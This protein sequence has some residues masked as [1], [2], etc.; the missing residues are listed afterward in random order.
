MSFYLILIYVPVV[1]NE[2]AFHY[3]HEHLVID[4]WFYKLGLQALLSEERLG[5]SSPGVNVPH[6]HLHVQSLEDLNR[7]VSMTFF[8]ILNEKNLITEWILH[9]LFGY[10]SFIFCHCGFFISFRLLIDKKW[11]LRCHLEFCETF[12][13]FNFNLIAMNGEENQWYPTLQYI[14]IPC[15]S[16]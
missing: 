9:P 16:F 3:E 11:F 14:T 12:L 7:P 6:H 4:W 10:F 15:I 8:H 13:P 1:E 5:I 2:E